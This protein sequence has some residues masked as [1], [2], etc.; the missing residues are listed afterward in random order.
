L[1]NKLVQIEI[2]DNGEG[3]PK[4][5]IPNIFDRFY[6]ADKSRARTKGGNGLGLS[7][8]KKLIETYKGQVKIESE[9]NQFT[10]VI[11]Q[12]PIRSI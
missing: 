11:I 2:I 1:K 12:F 9:V 8:A 5:D 6:R 4:E 3:I 7:I 10:K